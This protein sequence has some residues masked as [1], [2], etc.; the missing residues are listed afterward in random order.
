L[1]EELPGEIWVWLKVTVKVGIEDLVKMAA[2][3]AMLAAS[4]GPVHLSISRDWGWPPAVLALRMTSVIASGNTMRS[5][6]FVEDHPIYRDGLARLLTA[7]LP[8]LTV[9]TVEGSAAARAHLAGSADPDLCLSDQRLADGEG[10]EL[11][12]RLRAERPLMAVG[13]L[14]ADPSPQLV[15]RARAAGAVA[16]L[17]KDRDA[18]ALAAALE[19]LFNGG[20]VFDDGPREHPA[21]PAFTL[22]RREILSL[23][24]EGLLDK[25]IGER[26]SIT[27]STV[28]NHWQHLFLRLDVTNRTEAVSRAIRLGLI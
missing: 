16:C 25:Q 23:A 17:S 4:V 19:T 6:L 9:T 7:I 2:S 13:L 8:D 5:L 20:T 28:R 18:D 15:A 27:E 14:C 10:L 24:A 21:G 1:G 3:A 22:R 26:L 11:L 12:A